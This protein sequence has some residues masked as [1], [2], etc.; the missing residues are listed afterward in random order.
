MSQTGS[1]EGARLQPRHYLSIVRRRGWI[2]ALTAVA[3]AT[4]GFALSS[5]Q[6]PVYV[7]QAKVFIGPG[8]DGAGDLASALNEI[9]LSG[10]FLTSYAE[11]MKSRPLAGQVVSQEKLPFSPQALT[12]RIS[13]VVVTN[14]RIIVVSVS[15]SDPGRAERSV[16]TLVTDFVSSSAVEFGGKT[17]VLAS[18]LEPALAPTTPVSPKPKRDAALLAFL[19][20]F[21]GLGCAVLLEHLDNR[22]L[23][24]DDVEL[25]LDPLPILAAIPEASGGRK[26]TLFFSE[27]ENS[28]VAESFRILRT[29]A[30]FFSMSEPL[31]RVL[32]TSPHG[33]DGKTTVAVNL[34]ASLAAS[35]LRTVLV[36]AD[37]RRPCASAYF[38]LPPA[39]G[40]SD[41]L[42]GRS[43]LSE[44]IRAT[45]VANLL[46][47]PAGTV[48]PN[49]SELLGSKL[50]V[51][52][53]DELAA[54]GTVVVLD[55]PPALVVTDAPV[56]AAQMDGIVLVVRAG[57]T[58]QDGAR[59]VKR[60]FER[61][62][63]PMLGVVIN[64]ASRDDAYGSPHRYYRY[65]RNG[66]ALVPSKNPSPGHVE[67][68]TRSTAGQDPS[69]EPDHEGESPPPLAPALR[70]GPSA[71]HRDR[72]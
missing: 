28:H 63:A 52:V 57:R 47:V 45:G 14:T 61:I 49:P 37:L 22:I 5:R 26:R 70:A 59:E 55:S 34:A 39:P 38:E 36:E 54:E 64:C 44:A 48:P 50:M 33:Q 72:T 23:S 25:A 68:G 11:A 65:L 53:L 43:E 24:R 19:G 40:L 35:G 51:S 42:V 41:V 46:L 67:P 27:N 17:G 15:D 16:N 62:G 32:V 58:H 1:G 31:G 20:V 4:S 3:A 13:T 18:V 10:E 12:A 8:T 30:Q 29:N 60:L 2:V 9:T 21:L 66:D 71:R 6:A 7:A 69:S 56:L